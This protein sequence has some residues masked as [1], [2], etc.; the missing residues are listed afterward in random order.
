[1]SVDFR[2]AA[3]E[4]ILELLGDAGRPLTAVEVADQLVIAPSTAF[5]ILHSLAG[6]G[7]VRRVDDSMIR[8]VKA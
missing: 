1:M 8:W 2:Q 7:L 6:Y 4:L 3:N 5:Q